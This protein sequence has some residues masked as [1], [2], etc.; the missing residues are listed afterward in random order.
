MFQKTAKLRLVNVNLY[1]PLLKI[2]KSTLT[3]ST[4]LNSLRMLEGRSIYFFCLFDLL[5]ESYL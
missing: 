1:A 5:C 2:G 3:S 4:I